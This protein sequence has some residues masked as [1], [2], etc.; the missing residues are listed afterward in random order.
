M[1][2]KELIAQLEKLDG[3]LL[4]VVPATGYNENQSPLESIEVVRYVPIETY[5]GWIDNDP[6]GVIVDEINAVYLEPQI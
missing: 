6:I 1:T 5:E 3:S 2:V 4:V